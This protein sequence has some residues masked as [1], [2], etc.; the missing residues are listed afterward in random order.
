[1]AVAGGWG[2]SR[3][4]RIEKK[5]GAAGWGAEGDQGW[6]KRGGLD[7][8]YLPYPRAQPASCEQVSASA[9]PRSPAPRGLAVAW[10]GAVRCALCCAVCDRAVGS[11]GTRQRYHPVQWLRKGPELLKHGRDSFLPPMI[12]PYLTACLEVKTSQNAVRFGCKRKKMCQNIFIL[13]L[14]KVCQHGFWHFLG[15]LSFQWCHL[16]G[17][18][19]SRF[20]TSEIFSDAV[21]W[22]L[23]ERRL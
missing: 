3:P 7:P 10:R 4:D 1:M 18:T 11:A 17:V 12:A 16:G 19:L 22:R 23:D 14:K 9:G 6:E 13:V 21:N 2:L 5:G 15:F 20:L 8:I